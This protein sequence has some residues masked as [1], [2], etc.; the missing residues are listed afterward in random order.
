MVIAEPAI[1]AESRGTGELHDS[2]GRS[3]I[4][5]G[6]LSHPSY[7][8]TK[9]LATTGHNMG[10]YCN[11]NTLGRRRKAECASIIIMLLGVLC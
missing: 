2:Q 3:G 7:T 5:P 10:P 6:A 4:A 11:L 8:P 9:S 1:L